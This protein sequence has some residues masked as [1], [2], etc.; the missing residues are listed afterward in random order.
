MKIEDKVKEYLQNGGLFNPEL[1]DHKEVRDL[2][3]QCNEELKL[4]KEC[5]LNTRER[6]RSK[7]V[8]RRAWLIFDKQLAKAGLINKKE[9]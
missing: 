3:I 9:K 7:S 8:S 2:L 5:F 1:M 4:V 6:L